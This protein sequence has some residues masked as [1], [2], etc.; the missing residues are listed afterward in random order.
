[1]I[2][3]LMREK[4]WQ[5]GDQP[6]SM[7]GFHHVHVMSLL[8]QPPLFHLMMIQLLW[9]WYFVRKTWWGL[10]AISKWL[11]GS[12]SPECASRQETLTPGSAIQPQLPNESCRDDRLKPIFPTAKATKTTKPSQ[13]AIANLSV[14]SKHN[15]PDL[16]GDLP[17]ILD[18]L[19]ADAAT[20][21]VQ[22]PAT[23]PN[24]WWSDMITL[25][26]ENFTFLST[27]KWYILRWWSPLNWQ[28]SNDL[29]IR[30]SDPHPSVGRDTG[31]V[32]SQLQDSRPGS[33]SSP[34]R[35][36]RSS[37][38]CSRRFSACGNTP[39]PLLNISL[40]DPLWT[41]SGSCCRMPTQRNLRGSSSAPDFQ[42]S[43]IM[44][45]QKRTGCP[46][47][48]PCQS[49]RRGKIPRLVVCNGLKVISQVVLS[50]SSSI[51]TIFAFKSILISSPPVSR[52]SLVFS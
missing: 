36:R 15:H 7:V 18:V 34:P 29:R 25:R 45:L 28:S 10:W 13:P 4:H 49:C 33:W 14:T 12:L 48:P 37:P 51:T 27:V 47:T 44:L 26:I 23:L 16:L 6:I 46:P 2:M 11:G 8:L 30:E 50:L 32:G 40:P 38:S 17:P 21:V 22:M 41:P 43:R 52:A 3:I 9:W 35:S 5:E 19:W 42:A 39:P 31:R 1:M 20:K 24:L